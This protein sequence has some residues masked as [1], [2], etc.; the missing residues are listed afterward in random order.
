MI[1]PREAVV[2]FRRLAGEGAE[3]GFGSSRAIDY[4]PDRLPHGR[5]WLL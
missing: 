5:T 1:A 4:T 3:G 2:N